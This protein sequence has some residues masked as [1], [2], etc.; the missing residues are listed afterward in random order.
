MAHR[1]PY[2]PFSN[3]VKHIP[4]LSDAAEAASSAQ[5]AGVLRTGDRTG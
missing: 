4:P 1:D 3:G 5:L 2:L